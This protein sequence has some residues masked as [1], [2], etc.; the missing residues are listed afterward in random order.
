M[1][2]VAPQ[3]TRHLNASPLSAH[4]DAFKSLVCHLSGNVFA[5][6]IGPLFHAESIFEVPNGFSDFSEAG[7]AFVTTPLD[8]A[9]FLDVVKDCVELPRLLKIL[10]S[11]KY[12]GVAQPY[13]PIW[14]KVFPKNPPPG[15]YSDMWRQVVFPHVTR[16]VDVQ[17]WDVPHFDRRYRQIAQIAREHATNPVILLE[18]SPTSREAQMIREF[19]D[20]LGI[21]TTGFCQ[22]CLSA[23]TFCHDCKQLSNKRSPIRFY[24]F[25]LN[26]CLRELQERALAFEHLL[27]HRFALERLRGWHELVEA[28]LRVAAFSESQKTM[29]AGLRRRSASDPAL[30]LTQIGSVFDNVRT[31][32]TSLAMRA[33]VVALSFV[34]AHSGQFDGLRKGWR[35]AIKEEMSEERVLPKEL[36]R[37]KM[38]PAV[39]T[40]MAMGNILAT[41]HVVPFYRRFFRIMEVLQGLDFIERSLALDQSCLVKYAVALSDTDDP[42]NVF[43]ATVLQISALLV[44]SVDFVLELE[45]E[46]KQL[47]DRFEE[48]VAAV[49]NTRPELAALYRALHDQMQNLL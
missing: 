18:Q 34:R 33:E 14:I 10:Q 15:L 16:Q 36:K 7:L 3:V 13:A 26:H 19:R 23:T 43:L 44:Q 17:S 35:A 46:A 12:L 4:L 22:Q 8:V 31:R 27:V 47:W 28:A 37:T 38:R 24:E 21:D 39:K 32:Q 48:V 5:S 11:P 9:V 2:F 25:T 30:T 49:V 40:I 1:S 29:I 42:D 45:K 20:D 41:V 6:S